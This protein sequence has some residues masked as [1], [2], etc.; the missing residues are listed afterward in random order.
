MMNNNSRQDPSVSRRKIIKTALTGTAAAAVVLPTKWSTPVLNTVLT[1]AHAQTSNPP[2][3]VT[4]VYASIAPIALNLRDTSEQGSQYALLDM[5]IAPAQAQ[6]YIPEICENF[7]GPTD[8]MD[9]GNSTLYIRVNEDLS[10]DFAIDSLGVG[11][12]G[13]RPPCGSF[14]EVSVDSDGSAIPDAAITLDL[15]EAVRLSNMVASGENEISGQYEV[16]D[17]G[18]EACAGSF[19]AVLGATFPLA[20]NCGGPPNN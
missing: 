3:I 5:L 18:G 2:S 4:G 7:D 1:P 14:A 16:V 20:I 8:S 19:T 13:S 6:S 12:A 11:D 17:F 9:T 15:F 10:V